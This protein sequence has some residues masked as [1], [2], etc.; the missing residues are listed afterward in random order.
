MNADD[1]ST[2]GVDRELDAVS[3]AE[4]LKD[5]VQVALHGL[6]ADEKFLGDLAVTQAE[7]Y[8]SDNFLLAGRQWVHQRILESRSE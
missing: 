8:I 3:N 1:S 4:F 2:N 5:I 7:G 6:L